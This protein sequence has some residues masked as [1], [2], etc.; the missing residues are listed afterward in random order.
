MADYDHKAATE[1]ALEYSWTS[2]KE[3]S[4]IDNLARAYLDL[5]EKAKAVLAAHDEA[6][7]STGPF[8][9]MRAIL[10]E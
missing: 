4:D 10:E 7:P 2:V 8:E 5:R 6:I 3:Y 9:A 1:T